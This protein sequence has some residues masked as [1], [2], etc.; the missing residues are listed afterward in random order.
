MSDVERDRGIVLIFWGDG[1]FSVGA[2]SRDVR[3]LISDLALGGQEKNP[4]DS[5]PP[6]NPEEQIASVYLEGLTKEELR[7]IKQHFSGGRNEDLIG[8]LVL[9]AYCAGRKDEKENRS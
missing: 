9:S 2:E 4:V 5:T 8:H 1:R 6:K 7:I 3:K